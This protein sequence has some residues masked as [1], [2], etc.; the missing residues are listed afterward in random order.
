MKLHQ[1]SHIRQTS[2]PLDNLVHQRNNGDLDMEQTYQR[3][4][5]WTAQQRENLVRSVLEG[6]PI[7][8]IYIN[9]RHLV[10]SASDQRQFVF[11]THHTFAVV[12][13]KQRIHT[14]FLLMSN[15]LPMPGSWFDPEDIVGEP[16]Q[17]P[18]TVTYG[19][20]SAKLRRQ[21]TNTL[22]GVS[23]VQLPDL[24]SERELYLRINAGGTPHTQEDL[25]RADEEALRKFRDIDAR[26]TSSQVR[27]AAEYLRGEQS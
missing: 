9:E 11:G 12:D 18:G 17:V 15:Q 10:Q 1:W 27:R 4:H 7:G 26:M 20:L 21:V 16:S 3:D 24:V 13:G 5:V 14:L 19:Q 8:N 6:L 23:R 25:D 2:E 22:W